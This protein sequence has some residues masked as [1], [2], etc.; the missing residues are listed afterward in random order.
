MRLYPEEG[1]GVVALANGTDL[2]YDGLADLL[3][4]MHWQA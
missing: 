3:G 4:S 2:D 1:L